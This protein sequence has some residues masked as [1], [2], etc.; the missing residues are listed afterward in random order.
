MLNSFATDFFSLCPHNFTPVCDLFLQARK[1]KSSENG[2]G[3]APNNDNS[4]CV[5]ESG[6]KPT[7]VID[8]GWGWVV[9]AASFVHWGLSG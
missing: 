9:M 5:V 2:K 8:G 7:K 3:G 4:N 6:T 1:M